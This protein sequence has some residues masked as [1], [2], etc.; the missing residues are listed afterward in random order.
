MPMYVDARRHAARGFFEFLEGELKADDVLADKQCVRLI[1]EKAQA[2]HAARSRQRFDAEATF[3]GKLLF[4]KMDDAVAAWCRR[5]EIRTDPYNVLRYEGRERGPTQHETAIGPSLATIHRAFD[6][7]AQRVPV[8]PD[9]RTAVEKAG[10]TVIAPAFRLQHPLPFGAAG[11]VKYGATRADVERAI[12]LVA[13]YAATGGDPSRSWRYDCGLLIA[14]G[15][16]RPRGLLGE[17][18]FEAWPEVRAQVWD[19]A[20]VWVILL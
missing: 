2:E 12:Y 15:L 20:R 13:M 14:Y 9:C 5:R 17:A 1:I 11:E 3:R 19:A 7:L 6:R 8:L 10:T 18:R 4:G 16:E